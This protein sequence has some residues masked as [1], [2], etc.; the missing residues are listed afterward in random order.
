MEPKV[1][2]SHAK[3]L[4]LTLVTDSATLSHMK[5][6]SSSSKVIKQKVIF[7]ATPTEV[8]DLLMNSKKHAAFTGGAAKVS[9]KMGGKVEAYDGYI[10]AKNVELVKDKKIVQDWR[11]S[12]WPEGVWSRVRMEL[13]GVKTGTQL[14]FSQTG[15]PANFV[16]DITQGWND[17]YWT[18]M[19][20][21]L[22]QRV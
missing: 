15:V 14:T 20:A 12:D 6:I 4:K 9:S 11:A 8:Y 13:Q 3:R 19:Q 22:A 17:F 5:K 18:P 1:K 2:I 7:S 16:Q 21:W 10:E